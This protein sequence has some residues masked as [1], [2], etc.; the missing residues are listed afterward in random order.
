VVARSLLRH[1]LILDGFS[2]ARQE[3]ELQSG[4]KNFARQ[5]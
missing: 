1:L 3:R 5:S 4:A 2:Q